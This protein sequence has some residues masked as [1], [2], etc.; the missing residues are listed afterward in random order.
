MVGDARR[1][2]TVMQIRVFSG[3]ASGKESACNAGDERDMSL[4]PAWRRSPQVGNGNLLQY[5]CVENSTD[6][7]AWQATVHGDAKSWTQ[8]SSCTHTLTYAH[9]HTQICPI[10]YL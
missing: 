7:G 1:K 3:S 6:R 10:S 9:A 4:T 8:L 2:F 5:S